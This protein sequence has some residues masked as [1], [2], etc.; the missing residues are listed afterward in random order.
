MSRQFSQVWPSRV[1]TYRTA[2]PADP[3]VGTIDRLGMISGSKTPQHTNSR[4]ATRRGRSRYRFTNCTTGSNAGPP[5]WSAAPM[6][7]NTN[8]PDISANDPYTGAPVGRRQRGDRP[9]AGAQQAAARRRPDQRELA[10]QHR[11]QLW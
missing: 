1:S 11:H 9:E 5:P 4:S 8:E 10:L 2:I 6:S 3:N 7:V